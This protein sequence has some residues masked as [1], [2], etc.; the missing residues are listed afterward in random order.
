MSTAMIIMMLVS[1]MVSIATSG[2]QMSRQQS[3]LD[4]QLDFNSDEAQKAREYLSEPERLHRLASLGVNPDLAL[5]SIMGNPQTSSFAAGSPGQVMPSDIGNL[6]NLLGGFTDK[7]LQEQLNDAQI[8]NL[9]SNTTGQDIENGFLPLTLSA[10]VDY[11]G[12]WTEAK[13]KDGFMSEAMAD[14]YREQIPWVSPLSAS[15][16]ALNYSRVS[17]AFAAADK[18]WAEADTQEHLQGLYD[19]E[20]GLN[21]QA[22]K[23][24][25]QRTKNLETQGKILDIQTETAAY[26]RDETWSQSVMAL[27]DQEWRAKMDGAPFTGDVML[28]LFFMRSTDEG[29]EFSEKFV[30]EYFEGSR[31]LYDFDM[32]NK[33]DHYWDNFWLKLGANDVLDAG[34]TL[35][36]GA[37]IGRGRGVGKGLGMQTTPKATPYGMKPEK[38]KSQ[39][40]VDS[41]GKKWKSYQSV[42]GSVKWAPESYFE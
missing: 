15:E 27:Y 8:R 32:Q 34:S 5:S 20:K 10:Q 30:K 7:M 12:A 37:L 9:N 18:F 35:G 25:I 19:S 11:L 22:V 2:I 41:N 6:S 24:S 40:R 33:M 14:Y 26:E 36:S 42:D 39:V 23:E 3:M 17:E 38:F 1:S 4:Q 16:C 21:W 13:V 31:S 28:D 29:K